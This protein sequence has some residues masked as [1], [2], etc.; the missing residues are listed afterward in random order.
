M[1]NSFNIFCSHFI[2]I[3]IIVL[4]VLSTFLP[5]FKLLVYIPSFPN[6]SIQI[7]IIQ[8][9]HSIT[10]GNE[11]ISYFHLSMIRVTKKSNF[12]NLLVGTT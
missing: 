6:K 11:N 3:K 5:T 4:L 8:R 2:Q 10:L 12:K 9:K 7:E 1:D